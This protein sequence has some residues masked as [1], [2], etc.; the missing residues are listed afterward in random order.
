MNAFLKSVIVAC[1]LACAL[2]YIASLFSPGTPTGARRIVVNSPDSVVID[3]MTEFKKQHPEFNVPASARLVDGPRANDYEV[4]FFYT[5]EDEVICTRI[6]NNGIEKSYVS[7]F[8][9]RIDNEWRTLYEDLSN[10]ESREEI[11]EFNMRILRHVRKLI[12]LNKS[13]TDLEENV[14]VEW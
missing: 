2:V 10:G 5:E 14:D 7:L 1:L 6:T 11:K 12:Q 13:T 9:V 4:Y 3:A 8:S